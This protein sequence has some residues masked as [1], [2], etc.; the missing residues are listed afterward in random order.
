MLHM[1]NV[2]LVISQQ[3]E[4][5]NF[6]Y[7]FFLQDTTRGVTGCWETM[8]GLGGGGGERRILRLSPA[9]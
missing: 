4:L 6:I 2:A 5:V 9:M 7:V 1:K 3:C 8:G